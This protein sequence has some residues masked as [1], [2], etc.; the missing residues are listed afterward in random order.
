M[1]NFLDII[2]CTSFAGKKAHIKEKTHQCTIC[3]KY[4]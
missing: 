3:F 1:V 2:R 4:S